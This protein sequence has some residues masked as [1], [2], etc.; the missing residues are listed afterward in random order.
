MNEN[1]TMEKVSH[2]SGAMAYAYRTSDNSPVTPD[3]QS[4]RQIKCTIALICCTISEIIS[5]NCTI[6]DKYVPDVKHLDGIQ[7]R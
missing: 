7:I 6:G 3:A 2:Q 4:V 1:G 5:D